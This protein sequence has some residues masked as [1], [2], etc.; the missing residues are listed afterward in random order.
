MSQEPRNLS[1]NQFN[2]ARRFP[3]L[4][5]CN[6]VS[7]DGHFTIPDDLITGIYISHSIVNRLSDPIKFY[8]KKFTYFHTGFTIEIYYDDPDDRKLAEVTVDLTTDSKP[9]LASLLGFDNAFL[10]GYLILGQLGNL[11]KQPAGEWEF[12]PAAT[13]LDPFCIRPVARELSALYVR[14][15]NNTIGPF[16]GDIT[17]AAGERIILDVKTVNDLFNCLETPVS[18]TGTEITIHSQEYTDDFAGVRTINGVKPDIRGNINFVGKGCLAIAPSGENTLEFK[19]TCAEPCCT[20]TE[21]APVSQAIL[22]LRTSIQ[23]VE[24]RL[25]TMALQISFMTQAF[26]IAQ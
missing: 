20:C 24:S 3:L 9:M 12:A 14:N 23:E 7:I 21:L 16:T 6:P 5:G 26:Q 13:T 10:Y 25:A 18:D 2:E 8:I 22:D 1:W 19:D 15:G 17:L 11:E 4:F